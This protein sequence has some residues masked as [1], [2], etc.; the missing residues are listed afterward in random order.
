MT[1]AGT[2]RDSVDPI[3]MY[4][5]GRDPRYS[6]RFEGFG[7]VLSQG[8]VERLQN[9]N[10]LATGQG[11]RG[12]VKILFRLLDPNVL[13]GQ[14]QVILDGGI[15]DHV[16]SSM[17]PGLGALQPWMRLQRLAQV[18]I[19]SPPQE[20]AAET[21]RAA[22]EQA[23]KIVAAAAQH[24]AREKEREEAERRK[25]KK[26]PALQNAE[27]PMDQLRKLVG[28]AEVKRQ[29]EELEAWAWRQREL[30][31]HD[32]DTTPPS[33]HMSFSGGP[34]TGKTTVARIVGGLL[35]KHE[36]LADGGLHEVSRADLVAAF[37]GQTALKTEKLIEDALGGVLFI[38]EA[39]ALSEPGAGGGSNDFGAEALAILISGM[40]NHRDELC[41]IVA[42]YPTEMERFIDAN[43]GLASRI[44]RHIVFPDF[45]DKELQDVFEAMVRAEG[46]Q[47][48]P[49]ILRAFQPYIRRARAAAKP[50][51]WGN[52]RAVRNLVERGIANQSVRLRKS[53]K[54]P[55]REQL[56]HLEAQDFAFLT[57]AE[58]PIA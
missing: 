40:E 27:D 11:I 48:D 19:A 50:R 22:Q 41:V 21:A 9:G 33:L 24:A 57:A 13:E 10:Y 5:E 58:A 17:L 25:R 49:R 37:V 52:A 47:L 35:R 28:M 30:K 55:S 46:L 43:A 39:Y 32:L 12:P 16:V 44:S 20:S 6:F 8:V 38:D 23:A 45:T 31:T 2:W 14:N 29:V 15:F 51:Q 1:I 36:L 54:K 42:G 26:K 53:G 3:T 34:G 56:L 18:A 4:I 7:G